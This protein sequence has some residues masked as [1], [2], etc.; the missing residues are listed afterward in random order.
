MQFLTLTTVTTFIALSLYLGSET[1]PTATSP[2]VSAN[3]R[4]HSSPVTYLQSGLGSP[5]L[6]SQTFDERPTATSHYRPLFAFSFLRRVLPIPEPVISFIPG[7]GVVQEV[8]RRAVRELP[9][10]ADAPSTTD[11]PPGPPPDLHVTFDDLQVEAAERRQALLT[12]IVDFRNATETALETARNLQGATQ[13]ELEALGNVILGTASRIEQNLTAIDQN[14]S[15]IDQNLRDIERHLNDLQQ[16]LS[17]MAGQI[18]RVADTVGDIKGRLRA[19]SE[20]M[21]QLL[22][23]ARASNT[24]LVGLEDRLDTLVVAIVTVCLLNAALVTLILMLILKAE[25]NIRYAID[26]IKIMLT[27]FKIPIP[28]PR[29]GPLGK[30]RVWC[31]ARRYWRWLPRAAV[32]A[33]TVLAAVI[34]TTVVLFIVDPTYLTADAHIRDDTPNSAAPP[35]GLRP[36]AHWPVTVALGACAFLATRR[37][38]R[39][40]RLGAPVLV[41]APVGATSGT[42]PGTV[43]IRDNGLRPTDGGFVIGRHASLVDVVVGDESV[44]RRHARITRDEHGEFYVEDLSSSNG[45]AVNGRPLRPFQPG[46]IAV[47]DRLKLGDLILTIEPIR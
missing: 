37:L 18:S 36:G 11:A 31:D 32:S 4:N 29:P 41:L 3:D 15:T 45:T 6:Y 25:R 44:S 38:R 39:P 10:V 12:S 43:L 7:G 14:L 40:D 1:T 33:T 13:S 42:A 2:L 26:L 9:S 19:Q 27:E 22:A 46:A 24:R 16:N 5:S 30:A 47:E 20:M 34:L 21:A 23:E 17:T 35:A 28:E 8:V